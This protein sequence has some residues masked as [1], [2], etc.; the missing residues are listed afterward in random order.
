MVK[1][2]VFAALLIAAML[3]S[4]HAQQPQWPSSVTDTLSFDVLLPPQN[5][6]QLDA[7]L[8]QQ[9]DPQS[10]LYHHWLSPNEFDR[11]FGP[12]VQAVARVTEMLKRQNMQVNQQ[13]NDLHII[14]RVADAARVFGV[15]IHISRAGVKRLSMPENWEPSLPDELRQVGAII[16]GL[17][18]DRWPKRLNIVIDPSSSKTHSAQHI[19][20]YN[21]LKQAYGYPS[22]QTMISRNG[23]TRR[24]DGSGTT[25]AILAASD[26]LDTDIDAY[27][28]LQNFSAHAGTAHNPR[29]YTRRFVYGAQP[30]VSREEI[31]DKSA[32]EAAA[33]VEMALGGAPGARLILYVMPNMDDDTILASY[34]QIVRDNLADIVSSSFGDCELFYVPSYNNGGDRYMKILQ[35][36][37]AVFRQGNAQGITFVAASG[38]NAGRACPDKNNATQGRKGRFIPSVEWPAISPWVTGVGGTNLTTTHAAGPRDETYLQENSYADPIRRADYFGNGATLSGGYFGAGGGLST[39]Y[40]RPDYQRALLGGG[41][42]AMRAVPDIGMHAGGCPPAAIKPCNG[43]NDSLNGHDNTDRSAIYVYSIGNLG[44][45]HGTSLAAPEFASAVALRVELQGRQ[46]NINHYIYRLAATDP[47]AFHH[48]IPGYNGVVTHYA[49]LHGVYNYMT[50]TGTPV[51][52]VFAGVPSVARAGMPQTPGNP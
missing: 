51:V 10:P 38:D 46:G 11:R 26:V 9:H 21:D 6:D 37:D 28:S 17:N 12:S 45:L 50:G 52:A 25:I 41:T 23:T 14:A 44:V 32:F 20:W 34:Q 30:G 31:K 15:P 29:V 19:Y 27:F 40:P 8:K 43:G 1:Q 16:I 4:T 35:Q 24:L 7:L 36:Y 3:H 33:D 18:P 39:L 49:P 5:N 48:D 22:Y 47:Q 42:Q 2:T 13:G